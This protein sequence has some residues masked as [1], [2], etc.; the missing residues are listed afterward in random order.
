VGA[1]F[2]G[3]FMSLIDFDSKYFDSNVALAGI[4]EAG[5]GA[6]AGPV[7]AA[8]VIMPKDNIIDGI[9]DSKKLTP[10]KRDLLFD[11]IKSTYVSYG[12][13]MIASDVIDQINILEASKKAMLM[14][15]SQ[16][17]PQPNLILVDGNI[18]LDTAISQKEVIDGDA[19]SYCIAA[20]S[21][22]AKVTRDRLMV[23]LSK[24]FP[25][26]GFEKHKGYGTKVHQDALA[27]HGVLAIHRKSYRPVAR[28]V[29]KA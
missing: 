24:D 9:N 18:T 14:A 10:K 22:I 29:S 3:N 2:F 13:G 25:Q 6:W 28:I 26:Y 12:I 20:A 27:E 17:S 7:V 8:A 4:D 1:F 23:S 21:I 19:K 11:Q 5:R 16:L 15:V